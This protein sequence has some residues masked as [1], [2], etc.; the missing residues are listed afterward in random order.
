MSRP[1]FAPAAGA[2]LRATATL[3]LVLGTCAATPAAQAPTTGRA[4]PEHA[5]HGTATPQ[6]RAPAGADGE[7]AAPF[8][9]EMNASMEQ[10]M[11]DMHAP[12]YSGNADIDFLS[13]MIAHHQG[14]IDMARLQLIHGRDPLVRQMAEEIIAGQATEVAAMRA[15]LERL[16]AGGDA[17]PDGFPALGATRGAAP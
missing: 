10:M 11:R 8:A 1:A 3:G 4:A 6:P 17:A 14:A 12:G 5:H 13:M 16:R 9:R 15:R 2:L 7:A